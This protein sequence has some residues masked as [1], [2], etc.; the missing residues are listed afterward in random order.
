M[1]FYI[2]YSSAFYKIVNFILLISCKIVIFISI[3]CFHCFLLCS[4]IVSTLNNV[5]MP[6]H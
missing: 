5:T 1:H 2:Y 3:L 6:F 4:F